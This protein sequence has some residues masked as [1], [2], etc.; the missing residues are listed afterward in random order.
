MAEREPSAAAA[1]YGHLKV[2][3]PDVVQRRPGGSVADAVYA[4]LKPPSPPDDRWRAAAAK[5]R[6]DWGEANARA[7]G[8]RKLI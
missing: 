6:A 1:L 7:W 2:G 3:T 5:A 8:D 4:H